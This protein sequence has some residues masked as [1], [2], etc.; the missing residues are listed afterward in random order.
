VQENQTPEGNENSKVEP[1]RSAFG[2]YDDIGSPAVV[3]N[4]ENEEPQ[5]QEK[6]FGLYDEIGSSDLK[7]NSE[8]QESQPNGNEDISSLYDEVKNPDTA[9]ITKSENENTI[10]QESN[11]FGLYNE[12]GT[13]PGSEFSQSQGNDFGLYDEIV[14]QDLTTG[15][16]KEEKNDLPKPDPTHLYAKPQKSLKRDRS[17]RKLIPGLMDVGEVDIDVEKEAAGGKE[18][19]EKGM[20]KPQGERFAID[21]LK[22]VL[23]E[24]NKED[25][26]NEHHETFPDFDLHQSASAFEVLKIFLERYK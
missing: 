1:K 2:L 9:N 14:T 7:V 24:F 21:E 25:N 18:T 22:D 3:P 15:S 26:N 10:P 19:L 8:S 5:P 11:A 16:K 12:I 13:I 17:K 20:T 4:P 6:V 23:A